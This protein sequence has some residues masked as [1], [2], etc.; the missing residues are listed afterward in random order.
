MLNLLAMSCSNTTITLSTSI[1]PTR[2]ANTQSQRIIVTTLSLYGFLKALPRPG[3]QS[4]V[5]KMVRLIMLPHSG[6]LEP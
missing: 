4:Y 1:D 3:E 5:R 2:M 6:M